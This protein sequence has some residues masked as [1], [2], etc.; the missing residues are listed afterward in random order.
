MSLRRTRVRKFNVLVAMIALLSTMDFQ[1]ATWAQK[2]EEPSRRGSLD[3]V[4]AALPDA[5]ESLVINRAPSTV[6]LDPELH[7][8]PDLAE[9]LDRSSLGWFLVTDGRLEKPLAPASRL[10]LAVE[11]SMQFRAPAGIGVVQYTAVQVVVFSQ[12]SNIKPNDV[13]AKLRTVAGT[14]AVEQT[15]ENILKIS[16]A[17]E[18]PNTIFVSSLSNNMLVYSNNLKYLE[19]TIAGLEGK[20]KVG[21]KHKELPEWKF[22]DEES[23][24]Q[25]LRHFR[26]D[27]DAQDL[28]TPFTRSGLSYPD[29]GAIGFAL[30]YKKTVNS[31]R[32]VYLTSHEDGLRVASEAWCLPMFFPTLPFT[33][34]PSKAVGKNAFE[35]FFELSSVEERVL[36]HFLM[37]TRI[38]HGAVL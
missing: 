33:P 24:I 9:A 27:V 13:I 37:M 38:G 19:S 2:T 10:D 34:P 29:D 6:A 5:T 7:K 20:S 1:Q 21:F 16:I 15:N 17:T 25:M 12:D 22:L 30:S 3:R 14:S 18:F 4:L 28:T 32:L 26:R 23:D 35:V 11:A 31:M 36:F 8:A